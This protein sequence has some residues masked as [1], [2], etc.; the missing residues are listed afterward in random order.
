MRHG[1]VSDGYT[2]KAYLIIA[3]RAKTCEVEILRG[4]HFQHL[5]LLKWLRTTHFPVGVRRAYK[6][7]VRATTAKDQA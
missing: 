6:T 5:L 3:S 2:R 4:Q 7:H 1:Q